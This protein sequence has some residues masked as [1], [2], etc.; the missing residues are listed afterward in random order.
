MTYGRA[1][2]IARRARVV[3]DNDWAGDPDG[4]VALAHHLLAPGNVVEA[5]TSSRL[6]PIF[7]PNDGG[8]ARG[9][10]LAGELVTL[11]TPDGEPA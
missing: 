1:L 8:A 2:R 11:V 4:L 5:V 10:R 6:S 7:G 9:A 3:I